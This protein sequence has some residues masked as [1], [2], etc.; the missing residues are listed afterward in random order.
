MV[1]NSQ[2]VQIDH[3]RTE[4]RNPKTL[5]LDTLSTIELLQ[6]MN[7]EDQKVIDTIKEA[8]PQIE[9]SIQL[10][11]HSLRVYLKTFIR[12]KELSFGRI[13]A[14]KISTSMCKVRG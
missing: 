2:K 9:K 1:D 10:V 5:N 11:I 14:F 13:G 7:E 3:L 6:I 4:S 12:K 8:L